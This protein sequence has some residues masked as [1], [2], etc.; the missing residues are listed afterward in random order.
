MALIKI[1]DLDEQV[2]KYKTTSAKKAFL[3]RELKAL[4]EH[5]NEVKDAYQKRKK[6]ALY[7]WYL[8]ERIFE[9]SVRQAET[10]IKIVT[11]YK[12]NNFG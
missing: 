10:N 3:T 12:A 6:D 11:K 2:N 1:S 7:G 5:Y 8:G 4:T 9:G